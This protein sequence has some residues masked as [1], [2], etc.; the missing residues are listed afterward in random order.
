MHK[1]PRS[2]IVEL[3]P[4]SL[5]QVEELPFPQ[6]ILDEVRYSI[7]GLR[8]GE[9][10]DPPERTSS[11]VSWTGTWARQADANNGILELNHSQLNKSKTHWI[12]WYVSPPACCSALGKR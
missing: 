10:V 1:C 6:G 5:C 7:L 9:N 8:S 3:T 2:P 11:A 12:H 4:G